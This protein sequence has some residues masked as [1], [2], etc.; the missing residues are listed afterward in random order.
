MHSERLHS[1]A[2]SGADNQGPSVYVYVCVCVCVSQAWHMGWA[3]PVASL[4]ASNL[5]AGQWV[6]V[7]IPAY[8]TNATN[9][10]QVCAQHTC[11]HT[12]RHIHTHTQTYREASGPPCAA[13]RI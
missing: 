4:N 1:E 3:E 8:M 7:S 11:T 6:N 10:V 13:R 12:H 9:H 2:G 5:P